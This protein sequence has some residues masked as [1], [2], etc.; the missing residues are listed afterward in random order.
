MGQ[1]VLFGVHK[2]IRPKTKAGLGR[3]FEL[4]LGE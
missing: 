3:I 1:L 4:G 2:V